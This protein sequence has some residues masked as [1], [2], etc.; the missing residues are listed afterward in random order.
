MKQER[1]SEAQRLEFTASP[2]EVFCRQRQIQT[3]LAPGCVLRFSE[4]NSGVSF[5]GHR[6]DS[7]QRISS[8]T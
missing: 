2:D 3:S 1:A 4:P 7:F 6:Q 5:V 8:S